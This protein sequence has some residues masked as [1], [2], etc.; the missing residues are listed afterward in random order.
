MVGQVYGEPVEAVRDRRA[1]RT[2]GLVVGA[3]HEVVNQ[4]LRVSSEEISEG[5]FSFVSV[6]SILL[7]DSNPGQLLPPP[8]QII[9]RSRQFLLG[10]E[11]LESCCEPFFTG[12]SF[13]LGHSFSP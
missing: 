11:Q 3:E 6:E 2:S 1:R 10:L 7:G 9:A 5:C 4:E 12:S 8:R 13:M